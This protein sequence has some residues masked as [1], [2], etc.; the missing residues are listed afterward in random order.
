MVSFYGGSEAK[1]NIEYTHHLLGIKLNHIHF[2]TDDVI[3]GK[4]IFN[5][6][7]KKGSRVFR[8]SGIDNLV[9]NLG[10][11]DLKSSVLS[12][13]SFTISVTF[14]TFSGPSVFS[15]VKRDR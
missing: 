11:W 5:E 8:A 14:R 15:S 10:L 7:G 1:I 4:H 3:G 9:E 2:L 12:T 13:V 6:D